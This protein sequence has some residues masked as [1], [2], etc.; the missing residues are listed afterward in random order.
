MKKTNLNLKKLF[1]EIEPTESLKGVVLSRLAKEKEKVRRRKE[2]LLQ[3]GFVF[4][5]GSLA[6]AGIF[7][8]GEILVSDFWAIASL[9]LSDLRLVADYWQ[10]F[11][12]S[13]LENFPAA[14]IAGILLPVL[15]L[16]FLVKK[17]G[18]QEPVLRFNFR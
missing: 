12:W 7:F 8:G 14:E 17:Y 18:Q 11:G 13:L 15:L 9:A 5:I 10:E 2:F 1:F 16:M 3:A 6:W 4:S